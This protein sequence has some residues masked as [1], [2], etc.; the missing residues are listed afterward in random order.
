MRI[1]SV[2][3][4]GTTTIGEHQ[5]VGSVTGNE[6]VELLFEFL[7]KGIVRGA[8]TQN[9]WASSVKEMWNFS[10]GMVCI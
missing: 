6:E 7:A 9:G 2:L 1:R 4:L 10:P 5:S 3:F 8:L